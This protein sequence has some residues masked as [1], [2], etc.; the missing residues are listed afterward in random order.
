MFVWQAAQNKIVTGSE[1]LKRGMLINN[2][3]SLIEVGLCAFCK[4]SVET[5]DHL[6]VNCRYAWE[7]WSRI[8][9]WWE[10]VWVS[11]GKIYS[12]LSWWLSH[13][14]KKVEKGIWDI[15]LFSVLWSLWLER[16]QILFQGAEFE[17]E[18]LV[19]KIQTRV[20]FWSKANFDLK[21]YTIED[22]KRCLQGIRKTKAAKIVVKD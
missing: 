15:C 8:I 4:E 18:N 3:E 11:P 2:P 10:M 12:L 1:L 19:D 21:T 14:L 5:A 17:L 9:N 6:L 7:V 16:N 13:K 20:A 22:F